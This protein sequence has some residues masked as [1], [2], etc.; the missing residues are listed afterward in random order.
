MSTSAKCFSQ[1]TK[2]LPPQS[3]GGNLP[4][5]GSSSN[6]TANSSLL[7][8]SSVPFHTP[9]LRN[10]RSV[11]N[12]TPEYFISTQDCA[13]LHVSALLHSEVSSERLFG[14]AER[15]NFNQLLAI[16]REMFPDR[17]FPADVEGLVEDETVVPTERAEEV[18][19]WLKEGKGWDSLD[20]A[21]REMSEQ[22]A[23]GV[24]KD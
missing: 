14:F 15:W 6:S 20:S 12:Q 11:T 23:H 2:V 1:S 13:I 8:R 21:V 4:S 16:Y 9:H 3:H 22:F 18:L 10:P 5:R 17:K 24:W 19:G 7:V